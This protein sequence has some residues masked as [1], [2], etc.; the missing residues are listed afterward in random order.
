LAFLIKVDGVLE[1]IVEL[2]THEYVLVREFFGCGKKGLIIIK[3]AK[4]YN[5]DLRLNDYND[6]RALHKHRNRK[7]GFM[8]GDFTCFS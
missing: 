6:V 2:R 4:L 8:G 1:K 5:N 3:M 7:N